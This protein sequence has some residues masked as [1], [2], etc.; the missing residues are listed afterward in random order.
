MAARRVGLAGR[1]TVLA[2]FLALS[3]A[4]VA[5]GAQALRTQAW[6]DMA[7]DFEGAGRSLLVSSCINSA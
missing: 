7:D 1:L 6:D 2:I 5:P 4:L 3:V